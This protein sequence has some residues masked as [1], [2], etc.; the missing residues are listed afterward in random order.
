MLQF[1]KN[2]LQTNE[3]NSRENLIPEKDSIKIATCAL[4]LEIANSD[5]NLDKSEIDTI[6]SVMKSTFSLSDE[7]IENLIV[8]SQEQVESSVSLY[9]FTDVINKTFTEDQKFEVLKNL[10]RIILADNKLDP[11]E[12]HFIKKIGGNL[13]FYHKDLIA[14]KMEV[15]NELKNSASKV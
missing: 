12:E 15:K 5:D 2:I 9:E 4:F 14:A 10:W 7:A 8:L 6:Y 11:H 13:M 3:E 1:F